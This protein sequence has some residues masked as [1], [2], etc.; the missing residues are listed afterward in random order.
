MTKP[1]AQCGADNPARFYKGITKWCKECWRGKVR[2]NR[3]SKLN[4]YQQYDRERNDNPDRVAARKAYADRQRA[5]A[6]AKKLD[7][8]RTRKWQTAN[9]IKRDAHIKVGNAIARGELTPQACE[10]CGYGVGVHAHHED[11]SKPLDV[12]WLCKTCHGKRHREI[13]EQRR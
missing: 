11:Y 9:R 2:A 7:Q 10:R 1:C 4:Y 6:N 12:M 5:D 13:N 3:A 8:I